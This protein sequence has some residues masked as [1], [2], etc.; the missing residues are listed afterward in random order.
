MGTWEAVGLSA[1]RSSPET[2][3]TASPA[4]PSWPR[5]SGIAPKTCSHSTSASM[6]CR[7]LSFFFRLLRTRGLGDH[8]QV[9]NS[10]NI[11]NYMKALVH[12]H[13]V[14]TCT[15]HCI[16][17]RSIAFHC[18]TLHLIALHCSTL[19]Y[20]AVHCITLR[21]ATLRYVMLRYTL[22]YITLR[23]HTIQYNTIQ[24]IHAYMHKSLSMSFGGILKVS[25]IAI[26]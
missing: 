10:T 20:I 19:Q 8:V 1:L 5:L 13:I 9:N 7:R 11:K 12:I 25:D 16:T 26:P 3:E 17:L 4:R 21:D 18:I 23:Y 14:S 2:P 6:S 22:R 24:Y 15:L